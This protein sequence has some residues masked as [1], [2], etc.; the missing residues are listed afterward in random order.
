MT[1]APDDLLLFAP[2]T[3]AYRGANGWTAEVQRAFIAALARIGVVAA[4]ARS[5]GRSRE[6]AHRLKQRAG[7]DSGFARAWDQALARSGDRALDVAIA[8]GFE[9]RRHE[10]WRGGRFL[11]WRTCYDN[12]LAFAAL[13]TLDRR[14]ARFAAAGL[15]A[16]RLF[17]D[18]T[19]RRDGR[20][21]CDVSPPEED[22]IPPPCSAETEGL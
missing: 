5:V 16:R 10:I 8:A 20:D 22:G 9:P 11:G 12:H 15:D 1:D 4:A 7:A 19:K 6:S 3:L 14:E 2:V 21:T 17:V 13:R 18:A